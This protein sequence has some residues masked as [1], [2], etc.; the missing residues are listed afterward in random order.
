M[1]FRAIAES[2][3]DTACTF[4]SICS[5]GVDPHEIKKALLA[6]WEEHGVDIVVAG[7]QQNA[8]PEEDDDD[9]CIIWLCVFVCLLFFIPRPVKLSLAPWNNFP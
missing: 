5:R 1:D 3:L 9:A 2:A 7:G 4:A 8:E 6:W